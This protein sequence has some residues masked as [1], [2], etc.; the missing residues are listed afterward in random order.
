MKK[1]QPTKL[2]LARQ[3]ANLSQSKAARACGMSVRTLQH[4]EIESRNVAGA[5]FRLL[6]NLAL[7]YGCRVEDLIDDQD[8]LNVLMLYNS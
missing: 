7:I 5:P 8:T 6:L 1:E 4:Y 3:A 2:Q